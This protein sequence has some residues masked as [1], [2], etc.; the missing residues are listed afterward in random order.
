MK[1][2]QSEGYGLVKQLQDASSS[3]IQW[4]VL[5]YKRLQIWVVPNDSNAQYVKC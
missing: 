5:W 1:T 4:T 3:N 2:E